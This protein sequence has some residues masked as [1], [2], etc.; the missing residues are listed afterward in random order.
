MIAAEV[1][2][3]IEPAP[4]DPILR[5]VLWT[6]ERPRYLYGQL[7]GGHG[8]TS[9]LSETPPWPEWEG[10]IV[11]HYL[12]PFLVETPNDGN[13]TLAVGPSPVP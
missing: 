2:S 8:E 7:T 13:R 5:G 4:F 9:K 3:G 10:K 6:G 1:G 12:T 11:G